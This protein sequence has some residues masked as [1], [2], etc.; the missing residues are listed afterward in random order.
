MA[1]SSWFTYIAT[2]RIFKH[3]SFGLSN[4]SNS[5]LSFSSYPGFLESLD[6]FYIMPDQK[7]VMLQTSLGLYNRSLYSSVVPTSLFAW[8]RVR[9]ANHNSVGGRTWSANLARFNSGTYENQYMVIDNKLFSP[10]KVTIIF[11]SCSFSF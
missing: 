6:D 1:H 8:Q 2:N 5:R 10:G 9:I 4:V 11:F 3:Y 7:L